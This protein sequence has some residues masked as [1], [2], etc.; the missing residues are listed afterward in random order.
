MDKE[1]GPDSAATG[2]GGDVERPAPDGTDSRSSVEGGDEPTP[3]ET[4]DE[5]GAGLAAKE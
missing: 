3:A 1:R 2:S 5:E 4:F